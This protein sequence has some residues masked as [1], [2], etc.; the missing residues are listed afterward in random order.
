MNKKNTKKFIKR[1]KRNEMI[2]D[3]IDSI[4]FYLDGSYFNENGKKINKT[5]FLSKIDENPIFNSYRLKKGN[6][7]ITIGECESNGR[8]Y[9]AE[10][11]FKITE[12]KISRPKFSNLKI[13]KLFVKIIDQNEIKTEKNGSETNV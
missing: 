1:L 13:L 3:P 12:R 4:W 5:E 7:I 6:G 9:K 11:V 2:I 8:L 10:T